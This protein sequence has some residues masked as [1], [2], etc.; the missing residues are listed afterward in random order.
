MLYYVWH[1][2][3]TVIP[4][5]G[6]SN[7]TSVALGNATRSN[8][9]Q[10]FECA[11]Q[12]RLADSRLEMSRPPCQLPATRYCGRRRAATRISHVPPMDL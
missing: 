2:L 3:T 4:L 10:S 12:H 7:D 11:R 5:F 9:T 1:L 8:L 6:F